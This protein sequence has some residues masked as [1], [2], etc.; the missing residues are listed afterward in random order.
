MPLSSRRS[1]SKNSILT[2]INSK[3]DAQ[4]ELDKL[5]AK[6]ASIKQQPK[7]DAKSELVKLNPKLDQKIVSNNK[8]DI[9]I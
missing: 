7:F 4:P 8:D 5:N 2:N 9:N 3:F 1:S 6:I